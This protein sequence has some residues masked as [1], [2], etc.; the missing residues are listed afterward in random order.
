MHT[1]ALVFPLLVG[2]KKTVPAPAAPPTRVLHIAAMNDFHGALYE[3]P[4]R[5]EPSRALGGLPWLASAVN[6]LREEHP[7][8]LLLDAGDVF[9]GAWPVNA[10]EGRGAV[11]A[12]NLL[13]VD[14]AAVGN[15]EFDYGGIEGEHPLR[16]ALERGGRLAQYDWLT[17]NIHEGEERWSPEGFAPWTLIERSGVKVGVIGLT[18][19]ETPQTTLYANVADLTFLDVVETVRREVP[20]M[21]EAGAEVIIAVGHL[22]GSCNPT[23][24]DD[25]GEPC[26]PGGEVGRLLTELEPGT[27]D[28]LIAGH[29]HTLLH[30]RVGDTFVLE[31]RA[32]GHAIGRLDLV[33]G[34]DGVDPDAS[35]IHPAWFLE[36]DAV[37]PGCTDTPFPTAPIDVGGRTLTPDAGALALIEKLER[38]A[39]SLCDQVGC[40]TTSFGRDRQAQSPTGD[41][42]TDIMLATMGADVAVTN[43]GGLR[44]DL[45]AGTIRREHLQAVMPFDNR[46]VVVE[47]TGKRLERLL[48]IGSS[49]AHGILQVSNL[50][51]AFDPSIDTPTDLNGDGQAETWET[52]R[53][54][55]GSIRVKGEPLDP[56]ATYKVVT[57]DFLYDGGDHLGYAFEGLDVLE[58]GPLLREAMNRWFE[59]R[60]SCVEPSQETRI[61][62]GPCA[63]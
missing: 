50:S 13:G 57:V 37:D 41:L 58:E 23:A 4:K 45:P 17:A 7:D 5:G 26:T 31:Q 24:Y 59:S 53:L 16:G 49:G 63:G 6:T 34:P 54:C 62:I 9:Q 27:L 40:T 1:I 20:K 61:A 56:N 44:A 35:T 28:V 43:S 11:E 48:R 32:H 30:H 51:Y 52:K 18:T 22:T 15:H 47:M 25:P 3:K 60:D 33:V 8:L 55:D 39:G 36:H 12:F 19:Q 21:R 29:A 10:T 46:L 2:C 42:V 38:E 14:A